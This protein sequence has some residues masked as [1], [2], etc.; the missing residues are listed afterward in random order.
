[1]S[2]RHQPK[3]TKPRFCNGVN[4]FS[5]FILELAA[6]SVYDILS[7]RSVLH[8]YFNQVFSALRTTSIHSLYLE[9]QTEIYKTEMRDI[10]TSSSSF[11]TVFH[12]FSV[13]YWLLESR[14]TKASWLIK[15]SRLINMIRS[16]DLSTMDNVTGLSML[17]P[18]DYERQ[19]AS[20]DPEGFM[21]G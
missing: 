15:Q 7:L 19:F 20:I 10:V 2:T 14:P 8:V 9:H 21:T 18:Q 16:M 13:V 12:S 1:M 6:Y 5:I 4:E 17:Y 3:V 11:V